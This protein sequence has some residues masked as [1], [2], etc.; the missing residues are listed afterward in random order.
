MTVTRV[1]DAPVL[2]AA[3]AQPTVQAGTPLEVALTVQDAD[4]PD[5]LHTFTA[6]G[7]VGASVDAQGRVQW[8]PTTNQAGLHP[9]TATVTDRDGLGASVIIDVT[10]TA[11][12][13][14]SS[15]S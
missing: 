11:P 2:T 12:P 9:V 8:T 14:A 6:L 1:P 13:M 10:V 3:M 15:S 5:D 4:L 7:P